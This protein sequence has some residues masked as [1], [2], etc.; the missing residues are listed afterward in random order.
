MAPSGSQKASAWS[1]SSSTSCSKNGFRS[2]PAAF[3]ARPAATRLVDRM[4]HQARAQFD[5]ALRPFVDNDRRHLAHRG[6]EHHHSRQPEKGVTHRGDAHERRY[7]GPQVRPPASGA[8]RRPSPGAGDRRAA[9]AAA[10][11]FPARIGPPVGS[12]APLGLRPRSP[13]VVQGPRHLS[14]RARAA[15][16]QGRGFGSTRRS[17]RQSTAFMAPNRIGDGRLSRKSEPCPAQ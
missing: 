13:A 10:S 16:R 11:R 17:R 8:A 3:A 2:A 4:E 15:I 14:G 9:Q 6:D 7:A 5:V 1:R 12:R